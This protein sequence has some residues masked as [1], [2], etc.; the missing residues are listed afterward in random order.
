MP[1]YRVTARVSGKVSKDE[2]ETLN[3]ALAAL[4]RAVAGA[5][6]EGAVSFLGREYSPERQVAGRFELKGPDGVRAGVDVRGD[7]TEQP[8]FGWIRKQVIEKRSGE[9]AVQALRR[10]LQ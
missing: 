6:R 10:E 1:G 7:G 9:T 2:Y 4:E 5:R 8:Y 3:Q